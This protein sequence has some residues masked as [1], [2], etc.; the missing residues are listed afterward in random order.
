MFVKEP[1][2]LMLKASLYG[3]TFFSGDGVVEEPLTESLL[4]DIEGEPLLHQDSSEFP[5]GMFLRD[6]ILL[7]EFLLMGDIG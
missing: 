2:E 5:L 4:G 6:V 7:S 1:Y 3:N